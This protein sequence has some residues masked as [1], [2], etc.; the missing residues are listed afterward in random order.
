MGYVR[1]LAEALAPA[2]GVLAAMLRRFPVVV[3]GLALVALSCN[4]DDSQPN[5]PPASPQPDGAANLFLN[6]GLEDGADPW[7]FLKPDGPFTRTDALAQSGE[8]SAMF[9]MRDPPEAMDA[10]VYYLVQEIAPAEFPEFLSGYYRVEK[11]E[12]GT[13][14]QYLQFV[15]IAFGVD[16]LPGGFPNHQIRYILAGIDSPPFPITNA[17]FIFLGKE[18]PALGEWVRFE[19][20]VREDFERLW[21]AAPEGFEKIR[22]LFEVRW[23]SKTPGNAAEADVYYDDLY[24]GPAGGEAESGA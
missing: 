10:K 15:V 19:T 17:H 23:D 18:E 8:Y 22:I 6:P 20:N 4:G 14:K 11:W 16:N 7:F 13:P 24:F 3:L 12:K 21:G 1:I 2:G 5:G 9:E